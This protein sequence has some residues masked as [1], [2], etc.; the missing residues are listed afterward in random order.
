MVRLDNTTEI[1]KLTAKDKK[2][3]AAMVENSRIPLSKLTK[4]VALS[5]DAVDYRIKRMIEK[6]VIQRFHARINYA[7]LGYNLYHVFFLMD[8]VDKQKQ[9][10]LIEALKKNL[11]TISVIEYNDKWDL[12]VTL[13]AKNVKQFDEVL[14]NIINDFPQL[15]LERDKL[16]VI[17][18]YSNRTMR[19]LANVRGI[20][21][22]LVH[23]LRF[24]I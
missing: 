15:L 14:M 11:Y 6:K 24:Q 1:A 17:Q 2:I 16:V 21:F 8:E 18:E 19:L 22:H 23:Y 10:D 13:L 5:R 9:L 7:A 20:S 4:K 12:E 3:I